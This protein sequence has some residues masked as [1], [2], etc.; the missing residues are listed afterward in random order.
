MTSELYILQIITVLKVFLS[1]P[2]A[3]KVQ[4]PTQNSISS[5]SI[6]DY[7]SHYNLIFFLLKKKTSW[8]QH[9]QICLDI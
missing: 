8:N 9:F 7:I 1:L 5:R 4:S 2:Q 6:S 3:S